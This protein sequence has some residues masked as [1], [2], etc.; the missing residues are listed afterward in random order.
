MGKHF[1]DIQPA[2]DALRGASAAPI[3]SAPVYLGSWHWRSRARGETIHDWSTR[4]DRQEAEV[5]NHAAAWLRKGQKVRVIFDPFPAKQS[6][7]N[8][9]GVIHRRCRTCFADY[10]H[11]RFDPIASA[12]RMR[13]RMLGLECLTPCD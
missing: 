7:T 12:P 11:V 8:R 3:P 6:V 13:I 1:R 5:K 9:I 4:M 2:I 10:V